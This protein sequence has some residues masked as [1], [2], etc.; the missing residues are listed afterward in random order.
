MN[1]TRRFLFIF[2]LLFTLIL[3]KSQFPNIVIDGSGDPNEP[4]IAINP[5]NTAQIVAGSNLNN[6]YFSSD[7]G[8]TWSKGYLSSDYGV[9]GDPTIMADDNGNFY[10]FHLSN[11][12]SW[13]DRIVCQKSIDGGKTWNKGSYMG[14]FTGKNQDKQWAAYD[15]ANKIIYTT[16]TYF[17]EYGSSN[18]SDSSYILFSKSTDLGSSWTEAKRISQKAGDCLDDDYTA[19]G[20]VP[21]VGPN[22]E[23]FVAWANE[24]KIYFDKSFDMGKTWL[25]HDLVISDMPGGWA[26]N[27][28]GINRC[29]GLPVTVCDLSNGPF[30]GTIYVNWSDQRNGI[31][32]TDIW[33]SKSI[34]N[35]N[36]WSSPVRVNNDP[37]GRQQF[38]TWMTIDQST[39]YLYF[40]FYDRRN[41]DNDKTDVFI[42]VSRDGG[43]TF[44]NIRISETPFIPS[45][46]IFFGDYTNISAI[47]GVVRPIW[48]RMDNHKT[49]ILTSL[50]DDKKLTNIIENSFIQSLFELY[51]NAPNPGI[52]ETAI[53]F[54]L[55]HSSTVSL[56]LYDLVGKEVTTMIEA[57]KMDEG[58]YTII[59]DRSKISLKS[60]VYFYTLKVGNAL[61]TKKMVLL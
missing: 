11:A 33:L 14:Y 7:T 50:V 23:V 41:Y 35:G 55:R 19:E 38:L 37:A 12:V 58:K 26:F 6:F 4:S 48:T 54:K 15:P 18:S 45:S 53:S 27:V 13:I 44:E 34:D 31:G 39:G 16:W 32:D 61:K 46:P 59:I 1:G 9:W 24:N 22:G 17:N 57:R 8:K 29:N 5:N 42:A 36:T 43:A 60:G 51:D 56:K 25:E 3:G 40:V 20:A 28:P 52:E 21:A 10:F 47:D 49:S 30:R 2:S